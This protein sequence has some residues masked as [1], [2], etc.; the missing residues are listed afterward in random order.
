[1]VYAGQGFGGSGSQE[2]MLWDGNS[3]PSQGPSHIMIRLFI[4]LTCFWTL[5]LEETQTDTWKTKR[6]KIQIVTRVQDCPIDPWHHSILFILFFFT[7]FHQLVVGAM[8]NDLLTR[9]RSRYLPSSRPTQTVFPAPE[10]LQRVGSAVSE[11]LGSDT[12]S[13]HRTGA[14][15][16]KLFTERGVV[17][18]REKI[19]TWPCARSLPLATCKKNK[20]GISLK[21]TVTSSQVD[22]HVQSSGVPG[23]GKDRRGKEERNM[24]REYKIHRN[25]KKRSAAW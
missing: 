2:C 25:I 13:K 9:Q 14:R 22:F 7:S 16:W 15:T 10:A 5:N 8:I 21:E 19:S 1:M 17:R 12:N 11:W 4:L 18:F 23:W 24:P 6:N 3:S 20:A